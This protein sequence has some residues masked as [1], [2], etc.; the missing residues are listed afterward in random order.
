VLAA[1]DGSLWVGS[2]PAVTRF[3]NDRVT[4]YPKRGTALRD[5]RSQTVQPSAN[6]SI[7]TIND[8][9]LQQSTDSLFEDRDGRIWVTSREGVVRWDGH[10]FSRVADIPGGGVY[11]TLWLNNE[12][13]GLIRVPSEG[14]VEAIPWSRLGH[15]DFGLSMDVDPS[16][17]GL[18]LGFARGG[19]VV[20]WK[21]GQVHASYSAQ[22]GL[23]HGGVRH[24]RFGTRGTLWA[25]TQG[26]LSRTSNGRVTTLTSKNGLPCDTVHC[27]IEDN[28][29]YVWLYMPCGLVR[30]SREELD[31]WVADPR[32]QVRNTVY[33][34]TD[35]VALLA[36]LGGFGPNVGKTPDGKIW[37]NVADG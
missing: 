30:V 7:R 24:L 23:G 33:D 21:D 18:W 32:H 36:S 12:Q 4:I 27:S 26:G 37:F 20:Y 28:D 25:A 11:G 16:R 5:P 13:N 19:G 8:S 3:H 34:V 35:G 9:G 1:R 6:I 17:G 22:D 29:H 2:L 14:G 31:A 15:S 10:R